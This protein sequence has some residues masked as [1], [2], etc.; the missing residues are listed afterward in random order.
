M[1]TSEEE[2][3]ILDIFEKQIEKEKEI[4]N[5][6]NSLSEGTFKDYFNKLEIH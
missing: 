3:K 6:Y 1:N 4:V 5:L 2:K